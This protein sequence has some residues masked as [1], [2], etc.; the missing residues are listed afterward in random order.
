MNRTHPTIALVAGEASGDQLGAAL[1]EGLREL[2]RIG[3]NPIKVGFV[4]ATDSHNATPGDT[5]MG[6]RTSVGPAL[7]LEEVPCDRRVLLMAAA[8]VDD[9]FDHPQ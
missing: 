8:P 1:V 2:E 4:G 7:E 3:V 9:R 5:D 6:E